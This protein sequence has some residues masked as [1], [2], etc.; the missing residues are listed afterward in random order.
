MTSNFCMCYFLKDPCYNFQVCGHSNGQHQCS[1]ALAFLPHQRG[2]LYLQNFQLHLHQLVPAEP[3]LCQGAPRSGGHCRVTHGSPAR[4]PSRNFA[5]PPP[6][7]G[8]RW[9]K[10]LPT[11][12]FSSLPLACAV[13][14]GLEI[15]P[16]HC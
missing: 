8:N 6:P 14:I 1:T 7:T 16:L 2:G 3:L 10:S 9:W 15:L 4:V 5:S 11:C 13:A 12:P